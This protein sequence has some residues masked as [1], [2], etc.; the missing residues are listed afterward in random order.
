MKS[1]WV[2]L[3]LCFMGPSLFLGAPCLASNGLVFTLPTSFICPEL[4]YETPDLS[5][6]AGNNTG[7]LWV[8]TSEGDVNIRFVRFT[9]PQTGADMYTG[10]TFMGSVPSS[11]FTTDTVGFLARLNNA[12]LP[13]T[14]GVYYVYAILDLSDPDLTDPNCR[15]FAEIVVKVSPTTGALTCNN[16]VQVALDSTGRAVVSPQAVLGGTHIDYSIYTV[17][18]PAAGGGNTLNCAQLGQFLDVKVTS[19]CS[20]NFCWGKVRPVD[21]LAPALTC[22][23]AHISCA[24]VDFSPSNLH[25]NLGVE[26]AIPTVQENCGTP[27]LT[28]Q[29]TWFDL[30]CGGS[31][32]GV[33]E[34]SGYLRRRWTAR[35]A[36]G[37][38]ST[39]LQY[40]YLHSTRG[41]EVKMPADTILDCSAPSTDPSA[42]GAPFLT[43]FGQDFPLFPNVSYCE[44][45][46][47]FTDQLLPDCGGARK[48]LRRWTVYDWCLPTSVDPADPNPRYH[49]QTITLRDIDGPSPRCPNDTIVVTNPNAC[50]ANVLL[51]PVLIEDNCSLLATA[52]ATIVTT[53]P[54]TGDP[55]NTQTI[56]GT[57][58]DF[59]NNNYWLPDTMAVF[60]TATAC[61]P[62]GDHEVEYVF[63]DDCGNISD[64]F[65]FLSVTDGVPPIAVCDGFTRIA[66]SQDSTAVIWASTLDDGSYDNCAPV[67]FKVRRMEPGICYDA[68]FDDSEFFAD[69]IRFCCEDVGFPITL[70]LRVYDVEV[71]S[72]EVD[73]EFEEIHATDCMVQVTVE[74]KLP[75]ECKAPD[76]VRVFCDQFDP[77]LWAY[78]NAKTSDNCCLDNVTETRNYTLFD[79]L[80]NKGTIVRTFA[81]IDCSGNSNRCTQRVTVD[82]RQNYFVRFPDDVVLN[83]CDTSG[84]YGVPTFFGE[85]CELLATS[86]RDDTFVLAA[87]ACRKIERT[88]TVINWCTHDVNK[89]CVEIPNP[90]PHVSINHPSNLIGVVV[91]APGTTGTWA[92]SSVKLTPSSPTATNYSSF[93]SATANCYI[94]KQIIKIVDTEAPVIESCTSAPQTV[95]DNTANDPLF[96]NQT[97]WWDP[98]TNSHDLCEAPTD[99]KTT[100][101][102]ACTGGD[103]LIQYL[104]FLD[105]DQNGTLETVVNS[106]DLPPTNT[107]FFGNALNPNYTGGQP[108]S[109][110]HRPL[111][112]NQLYRFAIQTTLVGNRRTAALR[113]NT[114]QAPNTYVVPELPYGRHKIKWIVR[115]ACGNEKTCEYFFAV[116]DCKK[117]TVVCKQLAVNLM[118]TGMITLWASDFLLYGEDNCTPADRLVFSVEQAS[119]STGVFPLDA[120][121]QPIPNV[122]FDCDDL[123]I[124]VVRLWARD[125]AGNA[126]FCATPVLIQDN[127]GVCQGYA[128][129]SGLLETE[130]NKGVEEARV[131]LSGSHPALPP[132]ALFRQSD[133]IGLYSFNNALPLGS[134]YT[135]RPFK[136]DNPING[137]TTLDLAL[138]SKHILGVER[139]DS[140]YKIIAADANNTGTITTFDVVEIRKL[141]LGIY[142]TYPDNDSW[143]F[144]DAAYVF[145]DP[146]APFTPPFPEEIRGTEAQ[147]DQLDRNFVAV[148]I[149]DVNNSAVPSTVHALSTEERTNVHTLFDALI[150]KEGPVKTGETVKVRI[151]PT[152]LLAGFQFTLLHPGLEL[153]DIAPGGGMTQ[154]NFAA[155]QSR[156]AVTTAF[157]NPTGSPEL[158]YFT[159]TF[160][161]SQAGDVRQMLR[162]SGQITRAEAYAF[163]DD[164]KRVE[165]KTVALNFKTSADTNG[166]I[167]GMRFEVY[168]NAPNPFVHRTHIGFYLPQAHEA[169]LSVFDATGRLVYRATGDFPLG[170]N[171]FTLENLSAK[172]ML[173]YRIDANGE[174]GE[175]KMVRQ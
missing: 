3:I 59:P 144:V 109:F 82:Y 142:D 51:P 38:T 25:D 31:F 11:N 165:A 125:L 145:P 39:C 53:D 66:L 75:P 8:N 78:G 55:I 33:D 135:V 168:Q 122:S 62:V 173:Y 155:F 91:S 81:A 26:E 174:S 101:T 45:N 118:P 76:A 40:V 17:T 42:T 150:E 105:L 131:R 73:Q 92:P 46:A 84:Q 54:E 99:L 90:A 141:I 41:S 10:G 23:D 139:L 128:I 61:L 16:S 137:I 18:I 93:W 115:D 119:T 149:G 22:E 175:G 29:D 19:R 35:D 133:S 86:F 140:P 77:T 163:S 100:A 143:R 153:L 162:I 98:I 94:Y 164:L 9:T 123:G 83:A 87:D 63:T 36:V 170:Y 44:L 158:P 104:L 68:A 64:C 50:C 116:R 88:W 72:G 172:G 79:T 28:H 127:A 71:D 21:R 113:F 132:L 107:V 108:R 112:T 2:Q 69:S 1:V 120:N 60:S 159:L 171:R 111:P 89:G 157:E 52:M 114:S 161:A 67:R 148:K 14:S 156:Q 138:I 70:V 152:D 110:D 15:P 7:N 4:R 166:T 27:T 151:Q 130:E 49:I 47:G 146:T 80:C 13:S 121:N 65:F 96:W 5:L 97:E 32:N 95:C 58:S 20:G 102:D 6:C 103:L 85:D 124:Q 117:P 129:V 43:V 160:R 12:P 126:D 147:Q 37:N 106:A 169:T 57:F 136:D 167:A 30:G 34:L 74:D 24:I 56:K 48:I 154:L 134:D